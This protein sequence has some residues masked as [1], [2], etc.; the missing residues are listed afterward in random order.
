M[1]KNKEF[2]MLLGRAFLRELDQGHTESAVA[3]GRAFLLAMGKKG[4]DAE[5]GSPHH[6]RQSH[7][8]LVLVVN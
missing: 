3:F 8:H 2:A 5:R 7:E 4:P 1:T 6:G